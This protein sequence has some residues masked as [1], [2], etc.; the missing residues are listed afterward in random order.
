MP[1]EETRPRRKTDEASAQSF[2]ASDA[3]ARSPATGLGP[4]QGSP[5]EDQLPE[6]VREHPVSDPAS[7]SKDA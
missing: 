4:P 5:P 3:P 6:E 7:R 1:A 2:P